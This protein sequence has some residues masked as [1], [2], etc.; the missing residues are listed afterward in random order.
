[1]LKNLIFNM[2]SKQILPECDR[3]KPYD[4]DNYVC[5]KSDHL[6][7]LDGYHLALEVAEK[8][9]EKL[10]EEND[11]WNYSDFLPDKNV[12]ILCYLEE[13]DE[14][15][16]GYWNGSCYNSLYYDEELLFKN[17]TKWCY[18]PKPKKY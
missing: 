7:K 10:I 4:L 18:T 8:E 15:I 5:S 2:K 14:T 17:I 9:I 1:M 12:S 3:F 6:S 13:T 16:L 11:I